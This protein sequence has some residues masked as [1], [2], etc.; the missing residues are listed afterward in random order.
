MTVPNALQGIA[1]KCGFFLH[2]L[3]NGRHRRLESKLA[4]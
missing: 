2:I 1:E 3:R 4:R